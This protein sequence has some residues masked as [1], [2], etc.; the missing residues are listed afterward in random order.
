VAI[1]E[2]KNYPIYLIT[3]NI[4]MTQ[5]IYTNLMAT[6]D[7]YEVIDKGIPARHHAQYLSQWIADEARKNGHEFHVTEK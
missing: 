5:F 3:Y 1:A 7:T 2:G 4:E 6:D